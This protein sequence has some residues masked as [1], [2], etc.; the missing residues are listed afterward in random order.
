MQICRHP[1]VAN[2]KTQSPPNKHRYVQ[3]CKAAHTAAYPPP[4]LTG[5]GTKHAPAVPMPMQPPQ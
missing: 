1:F 3:A 4:P 5:P 2:P